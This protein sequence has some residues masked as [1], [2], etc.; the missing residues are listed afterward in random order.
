MSP[1]E[2][3]V[4]GYLSGANAGFNVHYKLILCMVL[5]PPTSLEDELFV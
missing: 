1:K 5:N 4:Q 3:G 2:T